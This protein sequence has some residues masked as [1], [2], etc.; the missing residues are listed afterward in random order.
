MSSPDLTAQVDEAAFRRR[1]THAQ[2]EAMTG[3]I[4]QAVGY[5]SKR[6]RDF[7][8]ALQSVNSG[9]EARV[10]YTPFRRA[11]LTL[12]DY[13]QLH[14]SSDTR[15][16]AVYRETVVLRRFQKRTGILLFHVTPGCEDEATTYIDYLT[17]AADLA[18]QRALSSPLWKTDKQEAKREAVAWAVE[19]LLPRIPVEE[20]DPEGGAPLPLDAYEAA[21]EARLCRNVETVADEI[22]KRGGD[23]DLWL[24]RHIKELLRI[25]ASRK[26]TAPARRDMASLRLVESREA[27][28]GQPG[29]PEREA[30]GS[31]NKTTWDSSVRTPSGH[32]A[33]AEALE[34]AGVRTKMSVPPSL[35]LQTGPGD[36]ALSYA[37]RGWAVFPL[38]NPDERGVCSCGKGAACPADRTGKHPR[39]LNGLTDATTDERQ[40]RAWWRKWPRANVGLA[41]GKASGL[42]ALDVDPRAGGD[43]SL[44]ELFDEHGAFETLEAVTGG[45]G[46][47]FLFAHPSV[48][49]KNSTSK[50]A[51]GLDVKTDGGYIV[52]A[53]SLHASGRR[54]QWRGEAEPSPMPEW[55][56]SLIL[57][58]GVK[59]KG[60][61]TAGATAPRTAPAARP[62]NGALILNGERNERLFRIACAHRGN[63]ATREE[64]EA[65]VA[66]AYETRCEKTPPMGPEE[67]R[68]IAGSAM[69]YQPEAKKRAARAEGAAT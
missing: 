45:G 52:A 29:E 36:V 50:L 59:P 51:E 33:E 53:P 46:F 28:Q 5:P 54:Y 42:V 9:S 19:Q 34:G 7:I 17:P 6:H 55:L 24:E 8:C 14:G 43:A 61:A 69:R 18:M 13:M 64:I 37:R 39:T 31:G 22:E 3:L 66:D 23:D 41:M 57:T 26:K 20:E 65:A 35:P 2:V 16:K 48:K 38:H 47:H 58:E 1:R 40:V 56:L 11:H 4:L 49:F 10:P 62:T 30:E 32:D 68:K 60:K 27:T 12:A 44:T 15:R 25:K 21:Q 63:G 67:F